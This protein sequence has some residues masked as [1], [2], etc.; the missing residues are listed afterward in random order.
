MQEQREYSILEIGTN[1][2]G[3]RAPFH[4]GKQ[5]WMRPKHAV[6]KHTLV[7]GRRR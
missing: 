7:L 6:T 2:E 4:L 3:A 5:S 1:Y